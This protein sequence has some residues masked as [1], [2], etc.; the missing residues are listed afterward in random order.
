[1]RKRN[2]LNLKLVVTLDEDCKNIDLGDIFIRA[3]GEMQKCT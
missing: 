3:K 1:M 2:V